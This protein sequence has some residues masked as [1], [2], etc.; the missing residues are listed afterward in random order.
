MLAYGFCLLQ[1]HSSKLS[2]L[3]TTG[4][5]SCHRT[6]SVLLSKHWFWIQTFDDHCMPDKFVPECTEWNT[7]NS[8]IRCSGLNLC[9]LEP[10]WQGRTFHIS[11]ISNRIACSLGC[12]C[13]CRRLY[14]HDEKGFSLQ[15]TDNLQLRQA[16]PYHDIALSSPNQFWR[17][18]DGRGISQPGRP[19]RPDPIS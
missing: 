18:K 7:I 14:M 16:C 4:R 2:L 19:A 9:R 13:T 15:R 8:K 17:S 3:L 5:L 12:A 1:L 10:I 6:R 11:N